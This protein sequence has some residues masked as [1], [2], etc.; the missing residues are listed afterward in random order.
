MTE[1]KEDTMSVKL[2]ARSRSG[3]QSPPANRPS[4]S[5]TNL[6]LVTLEPRIL[7]DAAGFMTGADIAMDAAIAHDAQQGVEAIFGPANNNA[8]NDDPTSA[9]LDGPW[10]NE[11]TADDTDASDDGD[12]TSAPLD[13]PWLDEITGEDADTSDDGD[14][15]GAP[16]DGPWLDEIT[17]EDEGGSNDDPTH[18][19]LD[20][21]WL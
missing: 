10:L 12:P 6:G 2:K 8:V 3:I 5:K 19:P 15:T 11:I 14:P 4:V 17:L 18:A 9:P 7:L 21:P 20:G 16:L 1:T 13:G